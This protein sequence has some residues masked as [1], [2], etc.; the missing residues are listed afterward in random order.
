MRKNLPITGKELVFD[1]RQ[2]LIT[3]TDQKGVITYCNDDF[4][5]VSGYSREELI[6]QAHNLIRHPDVPSAVFAHMWDYLKRGNIWMG[7][8]KNRCKNGDH[9]WVNAFVTPIREGGRVVGYES[10][11]IKASAEEERSASQARLSARNSDELAE[12][13][14]QQSAMVARF[15]RV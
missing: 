4:V 12:T 10:V 3:A 15:N 14:Q 7:V 6:G 13:A 5:E 11:R 8:V 2:R 1:E 9:Y